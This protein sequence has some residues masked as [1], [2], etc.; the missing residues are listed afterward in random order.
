MIVI[1]IIWSC[2]INDNDYNDDD[3]DDDNN[4]NNNSNNNDYERCLPENYILAETLE[5]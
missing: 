4:N 3:N 1:I 5:W 2:D